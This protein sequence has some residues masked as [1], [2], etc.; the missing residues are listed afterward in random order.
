MNIEKLEEIELSSKI[1][2]PNE[3][4]FSNCIINIDPIFFD[5]NYDCGKHKDKMDIIEYVINSGNNKEDKEKCH[6][7][8]E[9]YEQLK[10]N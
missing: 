4:C 3:D 5:V 6:R 2:C 10:K 9:T 8:E 7:C 1:I